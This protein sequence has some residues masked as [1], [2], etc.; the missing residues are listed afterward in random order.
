[1]YIAGSSYTLDG[2]MPQETYV[3]RFAARS[4]AG[5][6]EWGGEKSEEMPR[7]AAPEEPLIFNVDKGVTEIPYPN[8]YML[9]W[10]V[11]LDNGEKIN[12]FQIV[13][14]QVHNV[15]GKWESAGTK[16]TRE[17]EYPGPTTHTI[18]S[19]RSNAYYRIELRAHNDIGFSTPSEAV[20]KTPN[21]PTAE[22]GPNT[23]E[24]T[25]PGLGIGIII[26]I[27]VIA[28]LVTAVVVDVACF[29]TKNAGLTATIVGKQSVKDKDKEAMLEDGQ[30]ASAD[31][32]NEESRDE[33]KTIDEK[34]V[35]E[36]ELQKPPEK[37]VETITEKETDDKHEGNGQMKPQ[38][39]E[40]KQEQQESDEKIKD[41]TEPTETTPMIQGQVLHKIQE[42]DVNY[43]DVLQH[44]EK[45]QPCMQ[46][47]NDN[48]HPLDVWNSN[49]RSSYNMDPVCSESFLK[50][51]KKEK[52][53][54][55]TKMESNDVKF[56]SKRT[57]KQNGFGVNGLKDPVLDANDL[58]KSYDISPALEQSSSDDSIY[59]VPSPYQYTR[60]QAALKGYSCTEEK[61]K[62]PPPPPPRRN[63]NTSLT[64][65]KWSR[66]QETLAEK[67]QSLPQL[68]HLNTINNSPSLY[69]RMVSQ[70]V[71]A[72]V[73]VTS[74]RQSPF[75]VSK[76]KVQHQRT[77]S[78]SHVS[79]NMDALNWGTNNPYYLLSR[80]ALNQEQ[81]PF[82]SAS[83]EAL[84]WERNPDCLSASREA[85]VWGQS[86]YMS[87]S[88]EALN[89]KQIPYHKSVRREELNHGLRS[90]YRMSAS[91]GELNQESV[92]EKSSKREAMNEG[93]RSPYYISARRDTVNEEA[94]NRKRNVQNLSN[95]TRSPSESSSSTLYQ[96]LNASQTK[97]KTQ[98][99]YGVAPY[100]DLVGVSF[101]NKK[102]TNTPDFT[103]KMKVSATSTP[104]TSVSLV[105]VNRKPTLQPKV[106]L[107]SLN[108]P[109]IPLP[110]KP[111]E[112]PSSLSAAP[113]VE[114]KG[115]S[116]TTVT[117]VYFK[118]NQHQP[119][120]TQSMD[121]L[122]GPINSSPTA[123]QICS[124]SPSTITS[125]K[126]LGSLTESSS[127][128]RSYSQPTII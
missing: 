37:K 30:N 116:L 110:P 117:T 51:A 59:A 64:F 45:R 69:H 61:P 121:H 88:C 27:V 54:S 119:S 78:S 112:V 22:T 95:P 49:N 10:Q 99:A 80:E 29:F 17:V 92:Q 48:V 58:I 100:D 50:K 118:D 4:E 31:T 67:E 9:Q 39:E 56:H 65:G 16:T 111:S 57:I 90:L 46:S 66:S 84:N 125:A 122:D 35:P 44:H 83:R 114:E 21:D 81:R 120:H 109:F 101:A 25:E 18:E 85:L 124:F 97:D 68:K 127:S 55:S 113:N 36:K 14:Y 3:F 86:P 52:S 60:G 71:P 19:L 74:Q 94:Q 34:P 2:L 40:P 106:N 108:N 47:P 91:K 42:A 20:I 126:S 105:T 7:R 107:E 24:T 82:I 96:P 5:D 72:C 11:P 75:S 8:Q 76:S 26:A 63:P 70:Q 43:Q 28:V 123:G 32:L 77:G 33:T 115:K 38:K 23:E 41:S 62:P 12:F 79:S 104:N 128:Q 102:K 15:S 13:Y 87:S 73:E 53:T 6:G 89:L 98:I 103:Q 93:P 1:M